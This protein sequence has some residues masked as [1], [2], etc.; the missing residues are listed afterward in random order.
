MNT[1][2]LFQVNSKWEQLENSAK[3]H[4][5]KFRTAL[6]NLGKFKVIIEKETKWLK[7]L[8]K[9]MGKNTKLSTSSDNM[10]N[11]LV[12][13]VRFKIFSSIQKKIHACDQ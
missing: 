4:S 1:D 8:D 11:L 3:E 13:N 5:K 10:R 12:Q 6:D 9:K 7:E 2:F